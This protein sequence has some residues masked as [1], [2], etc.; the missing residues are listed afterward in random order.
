MLKRLATADHPTGQRGTYALNLCRINTFTLDIPNLHPIT[1]LQGKGQ[2]TSLSWLDA[3]T[4][5]RNAPQWTSICKSKTIPFIPVF[6]L[7]ASTVN[8]VEKGRGTGL[9]KHIAR[10]IAADQ[11]LTALK[12]LEQGS[13]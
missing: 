8:G 7:T 12:Q 6:L 11:A 9:Q 5:P 4:G 13:S 1:D 10:D 2:L 3:S